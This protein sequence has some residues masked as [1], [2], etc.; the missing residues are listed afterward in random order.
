M[1]D[2]AARVGPD[3]L[4]LPQFGPRRKPPAGN[5]RCLARSTHHGRNASRCART[6]ARSRGEVRRPSSA[7]REAMLDLAN[8]KLVIIVRNKGFRVNELSDRDLDE[9]ASLRALIEGSR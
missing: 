5:C 8:E 1:T 2:R 9:I 7:V 3:E 6:I 4:S